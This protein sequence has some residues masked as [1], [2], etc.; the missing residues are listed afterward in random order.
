MKNIILG[1]S[2]VL[3]G[4]AVF[5]QSTVVVTLERGQLSDQVYRV[6]SAIEDR[7]V[8]DL[9]RAVPGLREI[10]RLRIYAKARDGAPY[11]GL[12][13]SREQKHLA[14]VVVRPTDDFLLSDLRSY[15]IYELTNFSRGAAELAQL[16]IVGRPQSLP[17]EKQQISIARIEIEMGAPSEIEMVA[18]VTQA[19]VNS[20]GTADASVTD[21]I[22]QV[23]PQVVTGIDE[24]SAVP[25]VINLKLMKI[26]LLG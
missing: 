26:Y 14:G 24:V 11:L 12:R 21:A 3:S 25:G 16:V 9:N 15:D 22:Y 10:S 4:S 17:I 20:I 7:Y 19:A 1:L 8:L 2:L 18:I 6:E 23:Q 5:A 13:V